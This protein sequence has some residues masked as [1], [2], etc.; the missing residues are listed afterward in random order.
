MR[1]SASALAAASSPPC[2]SSWMSSGTESASA[3]R[4]RARA[5]GRARAGA[6]AAERAAQV[7]DERREGG[8]PPRGDQRLP[9]LGGH[10]GILVLD[11]RGEPGEGRGVSEPGEQRHGGA[12][13][14]G[15]GV[16]ERG[17][18]RLLRGA[19]DRH[20]PGEDR[21][22]RLCR[23]GR[24][25]PVLHL[26]G[27][28]QSRHQRGG[29]LRPSLDEPG[30]ELLAVVG[31]AG[32]R[33]QRL[34]ERRHVLGPPGREGLGRR[35]HLVLAEVHVHGEGKRIDLDAGRLADLP[36]VVR[37]GLGRAGGLGRC[38]FLDREGCVSRGAFSRGAASSRGAESAAGVHRREA[39]ARPGGS[40]PG[41]RRETGSAGSGVLSPA[42]FRLR[43]IRSSEA[44][45]APSSTKRSPSRL[46]VTGASS[47]S[48]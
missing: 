18:Q 15:V 46:E 7:G 1:E 32:A 28:R 9:G 20:G 33:G 17:E 23:E 45:S 25:R 11:P 27:S 29:G 42:A 13:A 19:P 12:A 39:R 43:I 41:R 5:A 21:P 24:R 40:A 37:R 31:A 8:R 26:H 22:P 47:L 16:L 6:S 44:P 38:G 3:S 4:P 10:G 2:S 30:D 34:D 48:A 14:R 36:A 35:R